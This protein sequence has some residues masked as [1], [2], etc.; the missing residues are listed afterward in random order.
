MPARV[1]LLLHLSTHG[2]LITAWI[3]QIIYLGN[4]S[5]QPACLAIRL[6][7]SHLLKFVP[8]S[9][10]ISFYFFLDFILQCFLDHRLPWKARFQSALHRA[11]E[12]RIAL[13]SCFL[14]PLG[15]AHFS[16]PLDLISNVFSKSHFKSDFSLFLIKITLTW[17]CVGRRGTSRTDLCHLDQSKRLFFL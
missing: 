11:T 17:V 2:F 7:Q 4:S 16:P 8:D 1:S 12:K 3:K 14:Q 5:Q 9:Q 10:L 6:A 15:E 13:L